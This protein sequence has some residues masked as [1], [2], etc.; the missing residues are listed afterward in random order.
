MSPYPYA[1]EWVETF[2][3]DLPE[4]DTCLHWPY[5]TDKGYPQIWWEGK[6]TTVSRIVLTAAVGPPPDPRMHA[7]HAPGICHNRACVNPRHLRWATPRQNSDDRLIDGTDTRGEKNAR[8]AIDRNRALAIYLDTGTQVSI[9]RR[10]NTTRSAVANIKN[11]Y[12]WAWLTGHQR[13]P[14]GK[15]R[16]G[17]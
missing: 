9:A 13:G 15:C 10:Y 1:R 12:T 4:S 3:A 14:G 11:G 7:A 5:S 6:R 17:V 2:I 8:S 16:E